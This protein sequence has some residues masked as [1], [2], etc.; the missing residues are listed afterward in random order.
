MVEENNMRTNVAHWELHEM[1]FV[2]GKAATDT[3]VTKNMF[4][5]MFGFTGFPT[6]AGDSLLF[7][8]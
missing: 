5:F 8:L 6:T 1:G 2:Y 7:F 4:M 3:N